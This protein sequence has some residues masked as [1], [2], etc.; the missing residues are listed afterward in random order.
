MVNFLKNKLIKNKKG[1]MTIYVIIGLAV[2]LPIVF[3][4][5]IDMPYLM[6]MNRKIKNTLDNASATAVTCLNETSISSGVIQIDKMEAER[7]AKK[8]IQESFGLNS[9]L[10]VNNNSLLQ[11]NPNITIKVINNPTL[12]PTYTTLNGKFNISN[13]SVVIY[14]EIPVRTKFISMAKPV[15]KYTAISQVQFK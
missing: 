3:F 15:I 8:V 14:G 12:E 1:F 11:E 13:P 10:T 6:T 2:F 7:M 4:V 5:S 9:D